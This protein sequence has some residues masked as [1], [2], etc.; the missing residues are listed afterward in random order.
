M[1]TYTVE[2]YRNDGTWEPVATFDYYGD[3][4]AYEAWLRSDGGILRITSKE[5][6]R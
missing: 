3:A 6:G 2:A 1:T 5:E 4:R